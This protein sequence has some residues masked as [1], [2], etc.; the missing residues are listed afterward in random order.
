MVDWGSLFQG[1]IRSKVV[2]KS[3]QFLGLG[4]FVPIWWSITS[5]ILW[6]LLGVTA[7]ASQTTRYYRQLRIKLSR[8]TT[9]RTLLPGTPLLTTPIPISPLRAETRNVG[10]LDTFWSGVT[11]RLVVVFLFAD[12]AS[13]VLSLLLPRPPWFPLMIVTMLFLG[14]WLANRAWEGEE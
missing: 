8:G 3:Q 7:F 2:V 1:H 12:A 11:T 5:I 13:G 9:F 10:R 14:A 6:L 4:S